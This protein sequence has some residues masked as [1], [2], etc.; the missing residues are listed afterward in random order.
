MK[1]VDD[2][3]FPPLPSNYVD[4]FDDD[5]DDVQAFLAEAVQRT[6]LSTAV[7]DCR[8]L[9]LFN[10]RP[11]GQLAIEYNDGDNKRE[12]VGISKTT[13]PRVPTPISS[14]PKKSDDEADSSFATIS[15]SSSDDEDHGETLGNAMKVFRESYSGNSFLFVTIFQILNCFR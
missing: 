1:R 8:D 14:S 11:L 12:H 4:D 9:I 15:S 6:P 7:V 2:I 5:D 10:P 13:P 3:K